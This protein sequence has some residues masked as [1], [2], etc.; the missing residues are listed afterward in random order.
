MYNPNIEIKVSDLYNTPSRILQLNG[1]Y[2]KVNGGNIYKLNNEESI[3]QTTDKRAFAKEAGDLLWIVDN[4]GKENLKV[5]N[6]S[7]E[8]VKSYSIPNNTENLL[9][10]NNNVFCMMSDEIKAYRLYDDGRTESIPIEY[11]FVYESDKCGFKMYKYS[12][13]DEICLWFDMSDYKDAYFVVDLNGNDVINNDCSYIQLLDF[14]TDRIVFT[15]SLFQLK[16][17]YEYSFADDLEICYDADVEDYAQGF[18]ENTPYFTDEKYMVCHHCLKLRSGRTCLCQCPVQCVLLIYIHQQQIFWHLCFQEI[19][20]FQ[21]T[22][23]L[24]LL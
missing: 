2:Y 19:L 6:S 9:I 17:L 13:E 5:L 16:T 11:S 22:P 18:F 4:S 3:F 1:E 23:V 15:P 24:F 8:I 20:T 10:S 14:D 7:G 21:D 12:C